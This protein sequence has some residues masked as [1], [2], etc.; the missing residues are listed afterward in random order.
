MPKIKAYKHNGAIIP[1]D[2]AK[3]AT[4]FRCPWTGEVFGTKKGYVNHL[5][6]LREDRIHR[7]IRDNIRDRIFQELINQ[8]SFEK[9]VDWIETHPEFLF[10]GVIQNGRDRWGER[11]EHL[12]EK[13]WVKITYLDVRWNDNVSNSHSCPRNGLTNWGREKDKPTGY[14]G[15]EGRIEFQV[16]HNFVLSTSDMFKQ[17]G[18]NT[19]G[20]GS[21]DGTR[22]GYEVKFFASDWL[23]LEKKR[24]FEIIKGDVPAR[25]TRGEPR[26]FRH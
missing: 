20:G 10:D 19:G 13:F 22:Y 21:G 1:V 23:G 12:R 24:L 9:I 25:Y 5:R 6:I 3:I 7:Q 2:D 15:W 8:P 4:A 17:I 16:S 18:V 11:R 26:Y 14:P